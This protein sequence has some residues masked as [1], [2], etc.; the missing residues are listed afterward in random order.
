MKT[1]KCGRCGGRF[2]SVTA[3]C[4]KCGY[5]AEYSEKGR[6]A[7]MSSAEKSIDREITG[8]GKNGRSVSASRSGRGFSGGSVSDRRLSGE[9]YRLP[10]RDA[11][12]GAVLSRGRSG[13]NTLPKRTSGGSPSPVRLPGGESSREIERR[14]RKSSVT[15]KEL[16]IILIIL[17]V[18]SA[19]GNINF[20]RIG[21]GIYT[22]ARPEYEYQ[23]EAMAETPVN[24]ITADEDIDMLLQYSSDLSEII[25]RRTAL[26]EDI[27]VQ[28][29]QGM[30]DESTTVWLQ[31]IIDN[32]REMLSYYSGGWMTLHSQYEQGLVQQE[33]ALDHFTSDRAKYEELWLD[34]EALRAQVVCD[35]DDIVGIDFPDD[36]TREAYRSMDLKEL[37]P[38]V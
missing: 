23:Q 22:A 26:I 28:R 4:P 20:S 2:D 14:Q 33:R 10:K 30:T 35:V 1:I 29:D 37:M 17:I 9:G 16:L 7:G 21:S 3:F 6:M 36:D 5:P 15:P 25:H 12:S 24:D 13:G 11:D 8:K 31:G 19:M 18:A 32:E 38:E 27:E 34:G